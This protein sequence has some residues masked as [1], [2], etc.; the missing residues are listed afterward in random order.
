MTKYLYSFTYLDSIFAFS[1]S[2]QSLSSCLKLFILP[3]ITV[4]KLA[5][6]KT[7]T[8][9]ALVA[10]SDSAIGVTQS[11]IC[12]DLYNET[13]HLILFGSKIIQIRFKTVFFGNLWQ[14]N[15]QTLGNSTEYKLS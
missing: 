5:S 6:T 15:E 9:T 8:F 7:G 11:T 3:F 13:R 4:V 14:H 10:A 1:Q 12:S 2:L